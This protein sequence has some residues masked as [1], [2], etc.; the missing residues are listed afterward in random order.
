[1]GAS[2]YGW[3]PWTTREDRALREQYPR[4]GAEAVADLVPDR[5]ISAIQQ[6]ARKIGVR[7]P[8]PGRRQRW[9]NCPH[10]DQAIREAYQSRP[11]PNAVGRLAQRVVRP[12]WWVSK[13]AAELG[14]VVPRN[15]D[16]PWSRAE[17][18]IL[19]RMA[20]KPLPTIRR[21]MA[22]SGFRRTET[23]IS[24]RRKR[25]HLS[26]KDPDHY[27]ATGL[28]AVLGVDRS[29]VINWIEGYGLPAKRRGTERTPQQGGDMWWIHRR[30]ARAWIRDNPYRVD[31]R[32]VERVPF[33]ELLAGGRADA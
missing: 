26:S 22:R 6:R 28:A 23:A 5:S 13:R 4:G 24:I 21:A 27:S 10:I 1:M 8:N 3:R 33:I 7:A 32:K 14:L 2:P 29:T 18:E 25:L 15:P 11:T 9:S 31:L 17:D 19:E 30:Q 16:P 20:H 12:R